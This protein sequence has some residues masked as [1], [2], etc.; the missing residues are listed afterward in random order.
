MHLLLL[1]K[2]SKGQSTKNMN[3]GIIIV[4][5]IGHGKEVTDIAKKL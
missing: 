3:K 1:W 5:A 2:S 4:G